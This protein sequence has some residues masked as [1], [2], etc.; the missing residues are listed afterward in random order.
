MRALERDVRGLDA[1]YGRD[2][3]LLTL[4]RGYL[5]S[6]IDNGR[7]VRFLAQHHPEVLREFQRIAE[8]TSLGA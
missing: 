8:A 1:S 7:V 3:V 6:L 4:A 2:V 5:K